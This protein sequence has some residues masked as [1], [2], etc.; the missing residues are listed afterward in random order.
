MRET[1]IKFRPNK[2]LINFSENSLHPQNTHESIDILFL[3][4]QTTLL[5]FRVRFLFQ[6]D[7]VSPGIRTVLYHF[8]DSKNL[9]SNKLNISY[10][11]Y[12][13]FKVYSGYSVYFAHPRR[14][15]T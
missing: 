9:D 4:T 12:L 8:R 13:H 10:I 11:M 3:A 1:K 5:L 6:T 7:T 15:D 14:Y 2:L